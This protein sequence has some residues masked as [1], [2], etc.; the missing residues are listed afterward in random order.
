MAISLLRR[1]RFVLIPTAC[2]GLAACPKLGQLTTEAI[3]AGAGAALRGDV[4]GRTGEIGDANCLYGDW[5]LES[6]SSAGGPNALRFG[7]AEL[8]ASNQ[9]IRTVIQYE[10][11]KTWSGAEVRTFNPRVISAP[12]GV[13][14]SSGGRL[15]LTMLTNNILSYRDPFGNRATYR[16]VVPRRNYVVVHAR[17]AEIMGEQKSATGHTYIQLLTVDHRT[18][19]TIHHGVY[20]FY[21]RSGPE[22]EEYTFLDRQPGRVSNEFY[23]VDGNFIGW[24]SDGS[25]AIE[26]S[27]EAMAR[28]LAT[29]RTWSGR[30]EHDPNYHYHL[31]GDNCVN[32]VYEVLESLQDERITIPN[33]PKRQIVRP[34][35]MLEGL[36]QVNSEH[37]VDLLRIYD[38]EG[39]T[40]CLAWK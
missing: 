4:G 29:V 22:D 2:L 14:P 21:P 11:V 25:I 39:Y 27:D 34:M 26:V 23:D 13:G 8:S 32:F 12:P 40:P 19:Q 3:L 20:G 17:G 35:A 9:S 36:A 1:L 24:R 15:G 18:R 10:F 16:K 28:A 31:I 30:S 6:S 37:T 5:R 7:R 33:T 38:E